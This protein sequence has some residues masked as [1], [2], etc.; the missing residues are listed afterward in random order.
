MFI[1]GVTRVDNIISETQRLEIKNAIFDAHNSKI[2]HLEDDNT[3]YKNSYGVSSLPIV[4]NL[5]NTLTPI[6]ESITGLKLIKENSYSRIYNVGST[7]NKHIDRDG[8]DITVSLQIE[9]TT[10]LPQPVFCE[11]YSGEVK[12]ASL[13]NG[14]FVI[15]RGRDLSHWR[16]PMES[17]KP[18]GQLICS[19]FHWRIAGKDTLSVPNFL[20]PSTCKS[21]I[22]AAEIKGFEKSQVIVDG[23][24][25]HDDYSRSSSTMWFEDTWHISE[26]LKNT[27]PEVAGL[28]VEG[29]QLVKYNVGEEFKAHLDCLNKDNDRLFTALIY[30]NDNFEG[31]E[32][33]FVNK[34]ETI[35]AEE[36]KLLMW[37]NL[38]AGK[39]DS[40]SLHSGNKIMSGTKYILVTWLLQ[41]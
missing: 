30:L 13:N 15:I 1:R 36:G 25:T 12:E 18:N 29:W 10:G 23:K 19:F 11:N 32:T 22:K 28:K 17:L 5:Y 35:I 41:L 6:V 38:S 24:N 14:D 31:G 7:L 33:Y 40:Q 16:N 20:S 34:Q 27:I 37:K 9:N 26:I 4:D 3:H 2:T 39:C 8:L 21:I